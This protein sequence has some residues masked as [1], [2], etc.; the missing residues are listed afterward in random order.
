MPSI[1]PEILECCFYLYK[2]EEAAETDSRHGGETAFALAVPIEGRDGMDQV[3]YA[4]TAKH[5]VDGGSSTARINHVD[6][7]FRAFSLGDIHPWHYPLPYGEGLQD[8]LAFCVLR[9]PF[10]TLKLQSLHLGGIDETWQDGHYGIGDP[11]FMFGRLF[12]HP[13]KESNTPTVRF[14]NIS[15]I[16]KDPVWNEDMDAF[17]ETILVEMRSRSGPSG[18]PVMTHK[19]NVIGGGQKI[20]GV[21]WGH[22]RRITGKGKGVEHAGIV[23]VTPYWRLMDLLFRDDV[24]EERRK[25]GE[26]MAKEEPIA[27]TDMEDAV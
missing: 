23:A 3:A 9:L 1:D 16:P 8:D 13:G 27:T 7:G 14:G 15:M 18:S 20:L 22:L 21:D 2:S 10:R 19:D 5:V 17:S 26:T 11:V 25:V 6:G 24:V 12:G 4:V